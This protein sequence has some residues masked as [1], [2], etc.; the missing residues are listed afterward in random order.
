MGFKGLPVICQAAQ[1]RHEERQ[2]GFSPTRE[3]H[4][5]TG[6]VVDPGM[7]ST[8]RSKRHVLVKRIAKNPAQN[9]SSQV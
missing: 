5:A 1:G 3:F 2:A 4:R 9:V 8:S 7:G 6:Q